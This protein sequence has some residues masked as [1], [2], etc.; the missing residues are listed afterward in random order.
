MMTGPKGFKRSTPP[1]LCWEFCAKTF[2]NLTKCDENSPNKLFENIRIGG[3]TKQSFI[4]WEGRTCAVVFTKGC[5]F[6][7][8]Y[9][10]NPSLVLKNQLEKMPDIDH[11]EIIDYLTSRKDWLDGVVVS[12]GEPTVHIDL[13][14][15]LRKIKS[16]GF[17]VKLDTNGSNPCMLK[18]LINRNLID[19]IAM[20]I[21]TCLEKVT[22][23]EVTNCSD[24]D[25]IKKIYQSLDVLRSSGIAYQLRTTVLPGHH[26]NA[27]MEELKQQFGKEH[28]VLQKFREGDVLGKYED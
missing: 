10:H 23:S 8:S 21:K 24:Q 20:D 9:C 7:C 11:N 4:D 2:Q 25:V 28:Y 3:F 19:F 13:P 14:D 5:N 12:G 16:L 1:L 17:P 6:R 26:T 15:F 22:Y 27:I 18:E